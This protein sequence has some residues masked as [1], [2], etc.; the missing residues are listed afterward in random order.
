[1]CICGNAIDRQPRNGGNGIGIQ[2]DVAYTLTSVDR[3]A[4]FRRQRVDKFREDDTASTRVPSGEGCHR[5][6]LPAKP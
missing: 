6:D 3:H 1:M 2:N 4:I 5:S